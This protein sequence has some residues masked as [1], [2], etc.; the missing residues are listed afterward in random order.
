[1]N[2]SIP[3]P[4]HPYSYSHQTQGPYPSSSPI[5]LAPTNPSLVPPNEGRLG[6]QNVRT[7]KW[8]ANKLCLS[9]SLPA[10]AT[11]NG[12]YKEE[13]R[14]VGGWKGDCRGMK[15]AYRGKQKLYYFRGE[16]KAHLGGRHMNEQHRKNSKTVTTNLPLIRKLS[17][18]GNSSLVITNLV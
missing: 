9:T 1:M 6:L 17:P 7:V 11:R 16:G 2:F 12:R 13:V 3:A 5:P 10:D 4:H 15:I 14:K 18:P 8:E